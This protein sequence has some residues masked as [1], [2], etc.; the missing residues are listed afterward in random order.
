M[1]TPLNE[2]DELESRLGFLGPNQDQWDLEDRL[3]DATLEMEGMV[4]RK[5]EEQLLPTTKDQSDFSLAYSNIHEVIRVEILTH[6][7]GQE[8]IVDSSNYTVTKK[9][10]R[11]DPT[12]ISFNQTW[13]EDNLHGNDYRLRVY[14]IP[15]LYKRLELRLAELDITVLSSIQ[16]GDEQRQAQ[17][18]KAENRLLELQ[19]RI[20]RTNQNI[21][22]KDAGDTLTA[23]YNFPGNRS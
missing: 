23:N 1:V 19:K 16:T 8:E 13:A 11:A 15:E 2:P 9:P 7:T 21:H 17:A 20:N 10:S 18:D 3:L 6:P 5:V 14:Y 12:N 22:D 4:G